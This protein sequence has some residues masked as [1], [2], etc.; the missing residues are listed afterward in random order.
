M[1]GKKAMPARFP[2]AEHTLFARSTVTDGRPILMWVLFAGALGGLSGCAAPPCVQQIVRGAPSNVDTG[3]KTPVPVWNSANAGTEFRPVVQASAKD[4]EKPVQWAESRVAET[5]STT[6]ATGS[7]TMPVIWRPF[8][9]NPP[10]DTVIVEQGPALVE[11]NEPPTNQQ[12]P[13]TE[14]GPTP[15]VMSGGPVIVV[16]DPHGFG[17][18]QGVVFG[19]PMPKAPNE[20]HKLSLPLYTVSPPDILLIESTQSLPTQ[21]VRGQ[22]LVRP[23]GTINLGIYG[24]SIYVAGLTLDQ[25]RAAVANAI[26][27]R[28]DPEKVKVKLEDVNVDVLAYNSK[29]YYVITDG[30]GYGEQVYRI[31]STGNETVL[32]AI[33]HIN[34]L[35]PVASKK[36]IWVARRSANGGKNN[37]LPVDWCGITQRGDISTNYQ[38]FPGDRL[39]VQADHLITTDSMLAKILSPIER[40]LG[41][42]LLG[43]STVNSIRFP[44]GNGVP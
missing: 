29:V 43:S 37:V 12:P 38:L 20:L 44:Q 42:T 33:A 14:P 9:K 31:P 16:P 4:S 11:Q 21:P 17:M 26:Q 32:D 10:P 13:G 15:K 34:G 2:L 24:A 25:V 36:H 23:D 5:P 18:Q 7:E 27:S 6:P 22:H 3:V 41:V 1:R 40:V 8:A 35:P 39:Y 28:L 19:P 30:G